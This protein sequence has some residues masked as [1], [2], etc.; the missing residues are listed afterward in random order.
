MQ[1]SFRAEVSRFN[2]QE[3]ESYL[4]WTYQINSNAWMKIFLILN[5]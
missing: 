5:A 4:L 3:V 2:I 1:E